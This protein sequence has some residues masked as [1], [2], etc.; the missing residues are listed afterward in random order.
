MITH[1]IRRRRPTYSAPKFHVTEKCLVELA[2]PPLASSWVG[3]RART[4][5]VW[6][7]QYAMFTRLGRRRWPLSPT[8]LARL[9]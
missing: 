9:A 1:Q 3:P 6:R 5:Q 7:A 4:L 2:E 8:P